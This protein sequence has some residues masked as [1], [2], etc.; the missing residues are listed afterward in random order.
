MKVYAN[1]HTAVKKVKDIAIIGNR[2]Q[3]K[4]SELKR[5]NLYLSKTDYKGNTGFMKV[6]FWNDSCN[7]MFIWLGFNKDNNIFSL[8]RAD[9]GLALSYF[10][11]YF[12]TLLDAYKDREL[13]IIDVSIANT[14]DI[15]VLYN[16]IKKLHNSENIIWDFCPS[17]IIWEVM[18]DD[19]YKDRATQFFI[20]G[21]YANDEVCWHIFDKPDAWTICYYDSWFNKN[22]HDYTFAGQRFKINNG[23]LYFKENI[24]VRKY[25]QKIK[26]HTELF[27]VKLIDFEFLGKIKEYAVMDK[28]APYIP[29]EY[30]K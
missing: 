12:K 6:R 2:I 28:D 4:K 14:T 23:I 24:P 26:Y 16:D 21:N 25:N 9:K 7:D 17:V 5:Y 27:A 15:N 22:Y 20:L 11:E 19:F 1:E 8:Y 3:L 18:S 10:K 29:E 30:C 13:R